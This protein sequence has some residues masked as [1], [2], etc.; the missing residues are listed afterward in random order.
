MSL[1]RST[2][3]RWPLWIGPAALSLRGPRVKAVHL[4]LAGPLATILAVALLSG[5]W[6]GQR[7]ALTRS[8]PPP[9]C[10]RRPRCPA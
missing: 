1:P 5:R 8:A 3:L 2:L 9:R 6:A 7:R 10:A 4:C